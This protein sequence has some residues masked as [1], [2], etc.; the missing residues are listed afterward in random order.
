M[1]AYR[2]WTR[3]R[4][5]LPDQDRSPPEREASQIVIDARSICAHQFD[6]YMA[7]LRYDLRRCSLYEP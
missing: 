1:A 2:A 7:S 5:E 3:C 4:G 6:P